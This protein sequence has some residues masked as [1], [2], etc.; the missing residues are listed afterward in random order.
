MQREADLKCALEQ[1]IRR[2]LKSAEEL[3]RQAA[4]SRREGNDHYCYGAARQAE[5]AAEQVQAILEADNAESGS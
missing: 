5:L 2:L 4:C 3:R 1:H